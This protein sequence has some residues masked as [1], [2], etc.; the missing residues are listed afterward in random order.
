H[1]F[2]A[3][4][5]L[6]RRGTSI[7][8]IHERTSIDAWF[9]RELRRLADD[10][11]GPFAGERRFRSVDTCAAEF[12]ARTP[13]YYSGWERS[14]RARTGTARRRTGRPPSHSDPRLGPESHGTGVRVRLLL[15]PR[16]NARAG[17]GPRRRDDQLHPRDGFPRLRPP[18]PP[19]LRAPDLGR[20]A[21]GSGG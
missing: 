10:P 17:V 5:E 21:R 2:E 4:L 12:P 1:R 16:R 8:T 11:A 9:L 14:A 7:A 20:C 15:R 18:R 13:Y 3:I 19:V 6:L